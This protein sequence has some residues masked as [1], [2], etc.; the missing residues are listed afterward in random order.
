MAVYL[1]TG[2]LGTGKSKWCT[3]R[4]QQAIKAGRRVA[5]NMDFY[6]D[7]LNP[8]TRKAR[9]TRLPDKPSARDFEA[10][11]H[12][13]PD[14]YDEERNG[15]LILDELGSWLNSRQSLDGARKAT[16]DWMIHARKFGWDVL[17]IVQSAMMIDKQVREG[18]GEYTVTCYRLDK[19]KLPLIGGLLDMFY[20]GAG[21]LPRLHVASTRLALGPGTSH[22]VDRDFFKGDD[23][24]AA[25][26]TRQVFVE[27]PEAAAFTALSPL[28]FTPPPVRATWWTRLRSLAGAKRAPVTQPL[29]PQPKP[30]HPAVQWLMRF[31]PDV[32]IREYGRLQRLG[33]I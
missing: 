26:D 18:I 1:V 25:Y 10:M 19:L 8:K 5:S 30:K 3:R 15:L 2:K 27:N 31:P 22:V 9:Y 20:E 28:Y 23:L 24:H 32:R 29:P 33:A 13:N 17:L 4:A 14:S 11:G 12:G 7:K 16:V 21:R 6:L